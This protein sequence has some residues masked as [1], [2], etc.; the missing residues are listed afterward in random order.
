[1]NNTPSPKPT[2]R[3]S[4]LILAILIVFVLILIALTTQGGATSF[5]STS[6]LTSTPI[7]QDILT[8]I[9]QQNV[10]ANPTQTS[11]PTY[12][13]LV[14]QTYLA[15]IQTAAAGPTFDLQKMYPVLPEMPKPE[16]ILAVKPK[17]TLAGYGLL[18]VNDPPVILH[19]D[20]VGL[21]ELSDL[22]WEEWTETSYITV[23]AGQMTESPAQGILWVQIAPYGRF[24]QDKFIIPSPV[25]AGRLSITGAMGDRLILNSEQGQ[26]FYFDVPG[27]R[28]VDSLKEK[29]PTVT[30]LPEAPVSKVEDAPDIPKDTFIFQ[31]YV[32]RQ[33]NI[34]LDS[35]ISAPEDYDWFYF[36][37]TRPGTITVSLLAQ[38]GNYGLKV[39]LVDRNQ[40]E[41]LI[42]E[43]VTPGRGKKQIVIP[44]APSGDYLVRV[45]SLDGS[46]SES[47]PY[48]L[49]FDAREP[50][51][52]IP[53]LEC[54]LENADGT[55]TAY[56]GY[57]N[58]NPFVVVLDAKNHQNEFEPPPTVR[59]GQPEGFIPG[60]VTDWFSVL[61]DGNDLV[62]KLD[63][64]TVTANRNSSTCP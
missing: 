55:Y 40:L 36:R 50:E 17:G 37:S 2:K 15:A 21:Y 12:F 62:W 64:H 35:F 14:T 30:P 56:F 11:L 49:R 19:G 44:D 9:A 28:F 20:E 46:F 60:R 7:P 16:Q 51:K 39:V 25:L 22:A 34:P 5:F 3:K 10:T 8:R 59:T 27:L 42:E 31:Q 29:I 32:S 54:V 33:V 1:M 58:P 53:I 13:D 4:Y 47:Q 52:V 48:T 18:S 63:G 24:Y 61:F 41:G 43:D 6:E 38:L 26:T 57:E 45:W 23:W